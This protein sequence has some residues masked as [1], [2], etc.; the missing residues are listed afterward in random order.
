VSEHSAYDAVTSLANGLR[1]RGVLPDVPLDP[2]AVV[3]AALGEL[4]DLCAVAD[5]PVGLSAEQEIRARALDVAGRKFGTFGYDTEE[6]LECAERLAAYIRDG[7][8]PR[9]LI[10]LRSRVSAEEEQG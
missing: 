6:L 7:A 4:D 10:D 1:A 3:S 8:E 5:E 2:Q 9:E